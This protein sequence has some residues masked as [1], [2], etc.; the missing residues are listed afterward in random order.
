M[1]DPR[2]TLRA[3]AAAL[4]AFDL[5]LA[6]S[7]L[8]A[9]RAARPEDPELHAA[10]VALCVEHLGDDAGA[11]DAPTPRAVTPTARAHLLLAAARSRRL[12]DGRVW[13][14]GLSPLQHP[15]VWAAWIDALRLAR[16]LDE[17]EAVAARARR[18]PVHPALRAS[19]AALDDALRPAR[20]R[21]AEEARAARE[22]TQRRRADTLRELLHEGR[23]EA[24]GAALLDDPP[25]EGPLAA[26]W[27]A[28]RE[29][30][31]RQ[32]DEATRAAAR[33]RV[34]EVTRA[35]AEGANRRALRA[36]A[37]L[38][39]PERA[40]VDPASLPPGLLALLADS[41][42][43]E[44][45]AIDAALALRDAAQHPD[46]LPLLR[47]HEAALR[48]VP[49][50]RAALEAA[51]RRAPRAPAAEVTASAPP[52]LR[53]VETLAAQGHWLSA[54]RLAAREGRDDRAAALRARAVAAHALRWETEADGDPEEAHAEL[55]RD[56]ALV[57]HPTDE[58]HALTLAFEGATLTTRRVDLRAGRVV[59]RAH[60]GLAA[61]FA[62][63]V[64]RWDGAL[65]GAASRDAVLSVDVDDGGLCALWPAPPTELLAPSLRPC[66]DADFAWVHGRGD[67]GEGVV[68]VWDLARGERVRRFACDDL[69]DVQGAA[70]VLTRDARGLQLRDAHGAVLAGRPFAPAG[71]LL[72][73]VPLP[74][75]HGVLATLRERIAPND[76]DRRHARPPTFRLLL[77][78]LAVAAREV[79]ALPLRPCARDDTAALALHPLTRLVWVRLAPRDLPGELVSVRSENLRF[80]SRRPVAAGVALRATA[81]GPLLSFVSTATASWQ[82]DLRA[83]PMGA[84]A[85][86]PSAVHQPAFARALPCA[87]AADEAAWRAHGPAVTAAR[88]G[89]GGVLAIPRAPSAA[90]ALHLVL[91]EAGLTAEAD[92]VLDEAR[93]RAPTHAALRLAAADRA[94][95]EGDAQRVRALLEGAELV[96]LGDT[97]AHARHLLGLARLEEGAEEGADAAWAEGEAAV[98]PRAVCALR[99]ARDVLR[100]ARGALA[101]ETACVLAA[102]LRGDDP[103]ASRAARASAA[104]YSSP[105]ISR[106]G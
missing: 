49:E 36:F 59:A 12:D 71:A 79:T 68:E 85:E 89:G 78:R 34:E 40:E 90:L 16:A 82:T 106:D 100:A 83:D 20:Q 67:Q 95:R 87:P 8:A 37:A 102:A 29:E 21:A 32:R 42:V 84:G 73:A 31:A 45:E 26:A 98:M 22:E 62:P 80:I 99:G 103:A 17:A 44:V 96:G 54:W 5:P 104:G 65:L 25:A 19:L 38:I 105:G 23:W 14:R 46:P 92:A 2:E 43:R 72:D 55:L 94:W 39:E 4:E 74:G 48:R 9:A 77:V 1:H 53:V 51:E 58:D 27:R 69:V 93:R 57:A 10:W 63:R 70:E 18:P 11:L 75:E 60:A 66:G 6:Q 76:D 47:P 7:L 97:A 91:A 15:E 56:D 50:G 28:L 33:R 86:V 64:F 3:A 35:L 81:R 61:P 88:R 30:V 24:V 52:A 13:Q 101:G 41:R